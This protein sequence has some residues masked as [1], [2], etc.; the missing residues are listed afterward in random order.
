MEVQP[1]LLPI[2]EEVPVVIEAVEPPPTEL[3]VPLE[4]VVVTPPQIATTEN[5]EIPTSP[6]LTFEQELMNMD[7]DATDED[8]LLGD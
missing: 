6:E 5:A 2:V 1:Q 7:I 8:A 3:P 4:P